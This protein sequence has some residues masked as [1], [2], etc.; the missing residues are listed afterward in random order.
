MGVIFHLLY[1]AVKTFLLK[2]R[3]SLFNIKEYVCI[4]KRFLLAIDPREA[5]YF[6]RYA[7]QSGCS[8]ET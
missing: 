5:S 1:Y 8:Y 3:I 7:C 2:K 4:D 6:T